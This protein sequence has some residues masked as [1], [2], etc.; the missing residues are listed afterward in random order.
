M[1][2]APTL[3][4]STKAKAPF[5]LSTKGIAVSIAA[6][7]AIAIA[8]VMPAAQTFANV[9]TDWDAKGVALASP[10]AA[11]E[12]EMA[13]MHLAIFDAVNSIERRYQPYL[14][15]AVAPM[16]ASEDAAAAAAAAAVLTALHP[17]A[18][19]D[20]KET[21]TSS[22]A[23]IADERAKSEGITLGETIAAEVLK[24]RENDGS[25]APDDYR[26]KTSP[27]VYVP[28]VVMVGST[29]PKM[30]PFVLPDASY[31]RPPPPV[32]LR[33]KEWADD[34][35][36]IKD[37]GA[38][39]S[40][41]RTPQQTENARFWLMV[42]PPAYH[43]L[44]RQLAIARRMSVID[45]ARFMALYSAALTDAY[46]AV[47]DAKY[48]Y[49]FWRPVTAIRN[50]DI[51]GNPD[52]ARD[53]TW[54]PFDPTPMHPEYPCA[55]CIESGAAVVVVEAILG[56]A[57]IPEVAMTSL[58]APGVTHR[59]T[60]LE[61]FANEIAEAR[62]C[63]GFHYRFS[64]RVGT[65]TGRKIGAYVVAHLLQPTDLA[66]SKSPDSA[67]SPENSI[68]STPASNTNHACCSDSPTYR[69]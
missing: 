48:H 18:A 36:E 58:S 10:G 61:A 40:A 49:E 44:P 51:G 28:T 1:K 3:A 25:N 11:G 63:A 60:N 38:K 68:P 6:R 31:F 56:S 19:A 24:A 17:Q 52:T 54:V 7:A 37:Y 22:V 67:P 47:F 14:A 32:S 12:R 43:Q 16:T 50:G 53:S 57:D 8:L 20:L 15:Q 2:S 13:I 26:P 65:E 42:G 45:G 23:A 5:G 66:G 29:W 46:I 64:T 35:N 4:G 39:A 27:G 59:W 33:S 34:Y 62:I 21:L 30:K 55:H 69:P 9:V 41:K